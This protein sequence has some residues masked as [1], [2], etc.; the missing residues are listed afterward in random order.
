MN[1]ERR[2][3]FLKELRKEREMSQE[4]L[5]EKLGVSN[6][7]VSRWETGRNLPDLS[8]LIEIADLYGV[9]IRELIDGERKSENTD[10]ETRDT[11]VKAADYA[12]Q[13]KKQLKKKM[14][15]A[16]VI[17]LLFLC[18]VSLCANALQFTAANKKPSPV[19]MGSYGD[20]QTDFGGK[21]PY[22]VFDD[23]GNYCI[24]TQTDGL[25]EEGKY[26]LDTTT[27]YSLTG[28]S[29]NTEKIILEEDGLYCI[30]ADG[31][32]SVVFFPRFSDTPMFIGNWTESW[33]GW[34][35]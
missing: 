17:A 20:N 12:D 2:G 32:L 14:I 10:R 24:Y 21:K 27:Q 8:I 23:Q 13:E 35:K 5:A 19:L 11:L 18:F 9:D 33:T 4:Q 3:K 25:L 30:A 22:L 15:H 29:G 7:T 6:R 1:M 16:A 26:T 28:A 31:E 34:H